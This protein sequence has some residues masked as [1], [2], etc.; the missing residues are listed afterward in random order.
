MMKKEVCA[1]ERTNESNRFAEKGGII[2]KGKWGHKMKT[3]DKY[4]QEKNRTDAYAFTH[5]PGAKRVRR[6]RPIGFKQSTGIWRHLVA[7][8]PR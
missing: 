6:N 8:A 3:R 5:S 4:R 7:G 1:A 2:G